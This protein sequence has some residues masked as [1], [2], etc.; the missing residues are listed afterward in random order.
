MSLFQVQQCLFDYLRALENADPGTKPEIQLDGYDLTD[1]ERRALRT[2]DVGA[3]YA[4]GTHPVIVNGYCRA[5]GFKRADYR[6][7][8]EAAAPQE[9]RRTRWQTS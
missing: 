3:I 2:G 1:E 9:R 8:L 5:M 6:P 7:L 4:M